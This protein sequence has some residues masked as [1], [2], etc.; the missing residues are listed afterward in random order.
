MSYE[1]RL[2]SRGFESIR[3]EVN[4]LNQKLDL[5][6][7]NTDTLLKERWLD[8]QAVCELLKISKRTLLTYRST[9]VLTFS[10]YQAKI[11]YRAS[12]ISKFLEQNYNKWFQ[13]C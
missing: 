9:V 11:F 8:N 6:I 13:Y 12:D 4:T 10:Q 5:L 2:L 7:E 1:L 3:E